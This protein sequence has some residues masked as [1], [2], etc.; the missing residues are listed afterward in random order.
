MLSRLDH[1]PPYAGG[2]EV[3]ALVNEP[4]SAPRKAPWGAI[5]GIGLIVVGGGAVAYA[6]TRGGSGAVTPAQPQVQYDPVMP[7][8]PTNQVIAATVTWVNPSKS[9]VTFGVQGAVVEGPSAPYN[10][11]GGHFWTSASLAQQATSSYYAGNV[12]QAAQLASVAA[13]RV[14]T[15]TVQPGATGI[16]TLYDILTPANGQRFVFLLTSNP[17]AGKLILSDSVG[18]PLARFSSVTG[19]TELTTA[20]AVQ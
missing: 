8:S 9:A 13:D 15:T 18:T 1:G 20:V 10:V 12:A 17:P 3:S 11:V 14:Y 16:A 6:L 5:L 7:F 2:V 19:T 4:Y